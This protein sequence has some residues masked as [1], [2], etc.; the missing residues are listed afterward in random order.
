MAWFLAHGSVRRWCLSL[1]KDVSGWSRALG[2][3]SRTPDLPLSSTSQSWSKQLPFLCIHISQVTSPGTKSVQRQSTC[4]S[5]AKTS[6]LCQ[7]KQI[8]LLSH[9]SPVFWDKRNKLV[10]LE[11]AEGE[12]QKPWLWK[13]G[14][15]QGGVRLK[16]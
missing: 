14:Y 10:D 6:K 5:W 15:H 3:D 12:T 13:S 2:G 11:L 4:Q 9:L 1:R 16:F 7:N 8:L